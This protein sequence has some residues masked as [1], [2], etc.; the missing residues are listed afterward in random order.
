MKG[1]FGRKDLVLL[2][3]FA[4]CIIG[5]NKGSSLPQSEHDEIVVYDFF[6][7]VFRFVASVI[8]TLRIMIADN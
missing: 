3:E 1:G 6:K 8:C 5:Y 2:K 4:E 7:S